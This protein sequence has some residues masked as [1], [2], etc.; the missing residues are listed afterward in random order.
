MASTGADFNGVRFDADA[1]KDAALRLDGLAD[2]LESELRSGE[3]SL[4]IPAAGVDEVS[5]R[6]AQTMNGVATSYTD[7]AAAG[8]LELRKLAATLRS[9]VRQFDRSESASVESFGGTAGAA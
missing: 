9:Q 5:Q 8:V 2:R 1:A 4:R 6:A 7:S 3:V